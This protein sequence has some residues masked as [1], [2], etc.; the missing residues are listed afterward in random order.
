M[1]ENKSFWKKILAFFFL[2]GLLSRLYRIF[3]GPFCLRDFRINWCSFW[4]G[5]KKEVKQLIGREEGAQKYFHDSIKIFSDYFIPQA[6][7]GHKPKIL[8]PHSLLV[9]VLFLT[10]LKFSALAYVFFIYP[11]PARMSGL[12]ENEVLSLINQDRDVSGL[13]PLV[14]NAALSASALKKAQDMS[15]RDYFAHQSPDGRQP[16][17]WIERA[18]YPYLY[19][20]E[21]LAMNFSSG[22]S[23]HN[24]LMA[25]PSH[26]KNIL[27]ER[28]HDVGLAVISGKINGQSTN[29]LV[30]IF[31]AEKTL[32]L[33]IA[34]AT[35]ITAGTTAN[36]AK[37]I[38]SEAAAAFTPAKEENIVRPKTAGP[39]Q[40]A[41][42]EATE[43]RPPTVAA[44][45]NNSS[46]APSDPPAAPLGQEK[47]P[48]GPPAAEIGAL[49][50]TA[51]QTAVRPDRLAVL[52]IPDFAARDAAQAP[53]NPEIVPQPL[54]SIAYF[55]SLDSAPVKRGLDIIHYSRL[56]MFGA[57]MF[58]I[59]ALSL[60]IMIR[61]RF[62]HKPVI[63]QSLLA[64]FFLIALFSVRMH[65]LENF[66]GLI[67]I[68]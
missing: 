57:I 29:I 32:D 8:R 47:L 48:A 13:P 26:R 1:K 55:P 20:G 2:V 67:G 17:D 7:N 54:K 34:P 59:G 53:D 39:A 56:I 50:Q 64:I 45:A 5:E 66:A 28:Y 41:V 42:P 36:Q 68:I 33:A 4:Q 46:P 27:N 60:N 44:S 37:I 9:I 49:D 23:A 11:N 30:Q 6:A 65:P 58:M 22:L 3:R 40:P 31:G 52:E 24:A 35:A 21:N 12:M 43:I 63:V 14:L 10:V 51:P 25:S 19:V 61:W 18:D 16:W 38:A 62:Q 15:E